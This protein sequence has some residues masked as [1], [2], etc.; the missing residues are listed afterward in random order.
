MSVHRYEKKNGSGWKAVVQVGHRQRTKNFRRKHDA[1]MW[2]SEIRRRVSSSSELGHEQTKLTIH[3]LSNVWIKRHAEPN[4]EKSSVVR[5]DCLLRHQILPFLGNRRVCELK[6]LE[7]E[8]WLNSLRQES[9]ISI[10]TCNLALGL[11][12]KMLNDAV[13]WEMIRFNPLAAVKL[14][15][16]AE[17]EMKYW[18]KHEAE[19]FLAS[20]FGLE[21]VAHSVFSVALY[22]GMRR[23]ELQALK[24]DCVDFDGRRIAVRRS[25]CENAR[26]AKEHTKS[27]RIRYV[28]IN[29]SL[30]EILVKLK[31]ESHDSYVLPQT[32]DFSHGSRIVRKLTKSVGAKCIRFHDL[33]H[34]FASQYMISGGDIYK[35]QKILGHSTIKQT[36]RYAHFSPEHLLGA[37]ENLDFGT[38]IVSN[39]RQLFAAKA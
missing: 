36:E 2:E 22:T 9:E 38:K 6:P 5:D 8:L 19:T 7:I 34:T 12:R 17:T 26:V 14:L 18:T 13:R 1:E 4:K 3:E 31:K 30:M 28:P 21:P 20:I 16:K 25:Y 11:L 10:T 24:W 23:G 29:T 39:V 15:R 33:R 32:F 37:T 27:K 35:L